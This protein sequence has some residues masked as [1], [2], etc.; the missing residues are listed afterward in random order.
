MRNP[1]TGTFDPGMSWTGEWQPDTPS[2][3]SS[4]A[5]M[6]LLPIPWLRLIFL[7]RLSLST[8]SPDGRSSFWSAGDGDAVV[9]SCFHE[10]NY[11][12]HGIRTAPHK[13]M[14]TWRNMKY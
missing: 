8:D 13:A 9:H 10:T 3:G 6:L 2:L 5:C 4:D 12:K 11:K 14:H 1:L 7:S